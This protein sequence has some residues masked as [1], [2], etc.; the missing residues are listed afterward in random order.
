M[1]ASFFLRASALA[2]FRVVN[3]ATGSTLQNPDS[4]HRT[5]NNTWVEQGEASKL[6]LVVSFFIIIFS[7]DVLD[8]S[9]YKK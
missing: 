9:P 5:L 8:R 3:A 2:S 1:A 7:L 4:D 6:D